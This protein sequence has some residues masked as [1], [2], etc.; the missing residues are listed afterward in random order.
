M[1]ALAALSVASSVVAF[2]DFGSKLLSNS[3]QIYKSPHGFLS[4]I[5]DIEVITRDLQNL[6]EGLRRKLPENRPLIWKAHRES[7]EDDEALDRLCIRCHEMAQTLTG[8]IRKLQGNTKGATSGLCSVSEEVQGM[9][10]ERE[11]GDQGLQDGNDGLV[12]GGSKDTNKEL[13]STEGAVG[14]WRR[15]RIRRALNWGRDGSVKDERIPGAQYNRWESFRK[16]LV[17]S[18]NKG[19]IEEMA[20]TLKD[21]R[22]EIEFRILVSFRYVSCK[23]CTIQYCNPAVDLNL[24]GLS[25]TCRFS[26]HRRQLRFHDPPR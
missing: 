25:T 12:N 24:V 20:T 5:V 8:R 18:W 1:E 7:S 19:E 26:S 14:A 2:V 10:V 4:P 16:A 15:T 6:T 3:R 22:S 23:C 11:L 9:K 17:V 13:L 21:F